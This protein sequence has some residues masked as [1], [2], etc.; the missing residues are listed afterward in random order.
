MR[1]RLLLLAAIAA[2][3]LTLIAAAPAPAAGPVN[4][5]DGLA[6]AGHDPVAY[7]TVARAT[8]GRADITAAHDG[9][10]YRFASAANRD[11]FRA[12][13]GKYLPQY[14]GYC[15]FGLARGYKAAID[16][17]AFTIVGGRLYLNYNAG[18]QA[19]WRRQQAADIALADA[20]W[21]RVIGSPEVNR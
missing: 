6:I 10:T 12:D 11:A 16:P 19:Q 3:S 20:N 7:F 9:V 13:P 1:R 4:A 18:I 2:P 17:K 14:G 5:E 15:A 8:P 21:P